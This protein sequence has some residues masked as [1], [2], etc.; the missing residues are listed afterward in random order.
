MFSHSA[1]FRFAF[2]APIGNP[3]INSEI[4]QALKEVKTD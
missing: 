3:F 1:V 2:R 4:K